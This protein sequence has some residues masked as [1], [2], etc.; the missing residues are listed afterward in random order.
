MPTEPGYYWWR[1]DCRLA[2]VIVEV[3]QGQLF[4][5]PLMWV[6]G[7]ESPHYVKTFGGTWGDK[8]EMPDE[9]KTEQEKQNANPTE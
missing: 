4:R 8:I 6:F 2:W 5:E 7:D 3:F 1:T 9:S